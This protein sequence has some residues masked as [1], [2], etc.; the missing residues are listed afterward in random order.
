LS[1]GDIIIDEVSGTNF[2]IY[3]VRE[4]KKRTCSIASG[5]VISPPTIISILRFFE[6]WLAYEYD[7]DQ[8]FAV[9]SSY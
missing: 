2:F 7:R 5:F 3:T 8:D 1:T 6:R 4:R 9:C